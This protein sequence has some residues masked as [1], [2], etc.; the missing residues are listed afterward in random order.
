MPHPGLHEML[1][2]RQVLTMIRGQNDHTSIENLKLTQ[3]RD[4]SADGLVSH[5]HTGLIAP[6]LNL[7]IVD[8][9]EMDVKKKT[10]AGSF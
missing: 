9:H 3:N 6:T 8:I 1:L 10:I 4:E 7:I 2:R 5:F